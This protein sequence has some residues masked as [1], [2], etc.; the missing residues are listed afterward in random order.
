MK[1]LIAY[2]GRSFQIEWY[3]NAKGNSQA[4]DYAEKLS[5]NDK[6]KL[7]N[8]LRLMGEIGMIRDQ[9]RFRNEGDQIYTFKPQPHR[10]LCF[11]F[12]GGKIIITNAFV[13]KQNKMPK[14]EKE[15][16]LKYKL[17]YI[18]RVQKGTY[19]MTKKTK[20]LSTVERWRLDGDFREQA[21]K[22]YQELLLSELLLALMDED[23][24][25]V[26][27]LAKEAGLS[28]TAIQKIRSGKSK[29][30]R[31]SNFVGVVQACGYNIVLEKEGHRIPFQF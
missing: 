10:F 8:L 4:L 7:E 26:R 16:A 3:F 5:Q 15:K 20:P 31:L 11:F 6:A 18:Q 24:K 17:D 23:E 19:I 30:M 25:S 12:D 29:D 21:D 9:T 22:E 1:E 13:K 27:Q 14:N 28:A 2:K